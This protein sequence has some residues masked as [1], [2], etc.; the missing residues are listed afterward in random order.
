MAQI[1]VVD[2]SQAEVDKISAILKENG[3]DVVSATS[4]EEGVAVAKQIKPDVVLMDIVMPGVNGFQ[5]TRQIKKDSTTGDIPVVIVTSKK[6]ETDRIWGERQG[7]AAY[8]V[9]PV[10]EKNL[11]KTI[12]DVLM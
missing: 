3:Y 1:L 10:E 9:K 12:A 2:D 6:Q 8:L 4:G 11:L 5:A 7:A